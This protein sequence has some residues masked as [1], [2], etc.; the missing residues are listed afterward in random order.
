MDGRKRQ[1]RRR[2]R[3]KRKRGWVDGRRKRWVDGRKQKC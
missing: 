1:E 3:V 2:G